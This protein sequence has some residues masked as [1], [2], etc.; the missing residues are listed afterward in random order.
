MKLE[1]FLLELGSSKG[2]PG[3]GAAAALTGALGAALVEMT[4]RLNDKRL[5]NSLGRAAQAALF[6]KKLYALIEKDQAAFR[7][8]QKAHPGRKKDPVSWKGALRNGAAVP[9]AICQTCTQAA[10]LAKK[11]R[12]RTSAWLESDRREALVLLRAAFDSAKLNVEINLKGLSNPT[13]KAQTKR[14]LRAWRQS[15]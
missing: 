3:G 1:K 2:S 14:K 15:L 10:Q 4:S 13:L 12:S 7:R 5:K 11:E 8:I 6:R 9:M